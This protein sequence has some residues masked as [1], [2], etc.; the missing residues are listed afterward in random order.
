MAEKVQQ[1]SNKAA[2]NKRAPMNKRKEYGQQKQFFRRQG[3]SNFKR[4][5]FKPQGEV[6][7]YSPDFAPIN[8]FENQVIPT[9]IHNFSKCFRPNL[10]TVRVQSLGMK[11]IPK[12]ESFQWKKGVLQF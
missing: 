11:F 5:T 6:N 8:I 4:S 10:A 9:G 2:Y 3:P 12:T 1:Q 7:L